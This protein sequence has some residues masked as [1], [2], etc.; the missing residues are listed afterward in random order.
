M[1]KPNNKRPAAN[2]PPAKQSAKQSPKQ[3]NKQ[4]AKQ[5]NK[6]DDE[7]ELPQQLCDLALDIAEREAGE[8]QDDALSQKRGELNKLVK[9][10]IFQKKDHLLYEALLLAK[11]TELAAFVVLKERADELAEVVVTAA[12]AGKNIEINAFMI[13]MFISTVGGLQFEQCFQ[14]QQAFE[15]LSASL[16]KAGLESE[17]ATVVLVHHAYHLD[18]VEAIRYCHLNDMVRDAHAA[19]SDKRH[20]ATPAID[21]SFGTWPASPF[22]PDDHAVELRFLLGFTQKVTDDPF[23][24]IPQ[25]EA[26]MDAYFDARA[27]RFERWAEQIQPVI[28]RCLATP[29]AQIDVNF[30]YQDLFHGA[31][32]RA[33][34][35]YDM[36]QLL[37]ELQHELDRHDVDAATL[38]A[39]I[40]PAQLGDYDTLRVQLVRTADETP[41]THVDK[42]CLPG[43]DLQDDIADVQDALAT[44]GL[45]RCFVT[46][47]FD[48]L[49]RPMQ[50][51]EL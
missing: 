16:Q 11:D 12:A 8:I 43:R 40:G 18:E 23:Y 19:L 51:R 10:A 36:L 25:D 44:L 29:D 21:R 26:E 14:D 47:G 7:D 42:P 48:N 39:I 34:A 28:K 3:S 6:P 4:P 38:K 41:L 33:L 30:Q 32:D 1:N 20:A 31:R 2:K 50:P 13:P 17:A 46:E 22:G 27:A 5:S 9:R 37:S 24:R 15:Q 35:E 45:E 49:G